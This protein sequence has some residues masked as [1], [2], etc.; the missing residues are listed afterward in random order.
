MRINFRGFLFSIFLLFLHCFFGGG[1][2]REREREKAYSYNRPRFESDPKVP[3]SNCVISLPSRF[4]NTAE[5]RGGRVAENVW[6]REVGGCAFV[7][8]R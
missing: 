7:W 6:E 1:W 5:G 2:E 3:V 8:V 4:L